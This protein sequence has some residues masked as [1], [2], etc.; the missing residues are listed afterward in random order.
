M[1]TLYFESLVARG[2]SEG[3]AR[4]FATIIDELHSCLCHL[5]TSNYDLVKEVQA[6][7]TNFA[8]IEELKI[9]HP[10]TPYTLEFVRPTAEQ[11]EALCLSYGHLLNE[12]SEIY[13]TVDDLEPLELEGEVVDLCEFYGIK[14]DV[15]SFY[16]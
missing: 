1:S 14:S 13:V 12:N 6:E 2:M 8:K 4:Q 3:R 5:D 10:T 7:L 15:V 11:W 16:R 9:L